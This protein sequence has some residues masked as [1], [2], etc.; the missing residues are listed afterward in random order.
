MKEILVR[1]N[2]RFMD[3]KIIVLSELNIDKHT[4]YK[5]LKS[6]INEIKELKP[7]QILIP[8]NLYNYNRNDNCDKTIVN[9]FLNELA[10]KTEVYYVKGKNEYKSIVDIYPDNK[11]NVLCNLNEKIPYQKK[12]HVNGLNVYGMR[13]GVTYY[14]KDY[15]EK[16]SDL[17]YKYCGYFDNL[18]LKENDVNILICYDSLIKHLYDYS[19]VLQQFDLVITS[20]NHK[21]KEQLIQKGSTLFF[22]ADPINN[23]KKLIPRFN[24]DNYDILNCEYYNTR[25]LIRKR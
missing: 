21:E 19:K 20:N 3:K 6:I 12:I 4:K 14:K 13:L 16:L 1:I 22:L 5:K 8:G 7:T 10:K 23:E 24:N 11:L 25:S 15:N 17:I 9:E 18:Y 2:K